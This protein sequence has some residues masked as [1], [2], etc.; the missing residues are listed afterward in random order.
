MVGG[1]TT[2]QFSENFKAV[3]LEL[4]EDQLQRLNDVSRLP[5]IYPYWH[6]HNFA[7]DRFTPA[8]QA[9]HADYPDRHYGG[10]DRLV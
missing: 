7:R 9:L 1:R 3:D 2:E 10:E 8:D 5:L 4:T 6:Q